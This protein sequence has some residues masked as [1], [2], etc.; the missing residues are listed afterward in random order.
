[1]NKRK[2]VTIIIII[3]IILLI[4]IGIINYKSTHPKNNETNQVELSIKEKIQK[5]LEE[6]YGDEDSIIKYSM[7]NDEFY[8]YVKNTKKDETLVERYNVKKDD[9]NNITVSPIVGVSG[10]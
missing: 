3:L 6:K 9:I 1:M 7:E 10:E 8:I 4:I 5:L 2:I